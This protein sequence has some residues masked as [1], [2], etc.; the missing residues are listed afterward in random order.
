MSRPDAESP[1]PRGWLADAWLPL[2]VVAIG[3][4][5]VAVVALRP[6]DFNP[7]GP[8]RIGTMLPAERFWTASTRVD[9]GVGYDG[10]WFFYVA[11]DPFM[12][13]PDPESFLDR[14]GYRYARILYPALAW[15]L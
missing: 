15:L 7:T 13:S 2:L 10:Q 11:N 4:V 14:P 12:R 1:R 5:A 3:Y 8:I 6:Y 9:P